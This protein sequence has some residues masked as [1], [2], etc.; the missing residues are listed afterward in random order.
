MI[1]YDRL[2]KGRNVALSTKKWNVGSAPCLPS[3]AGPSIQRTSRGV[4][5]LLVPCIVQRYTRPHLL[6]IDTVRK[7][8]PQ[9]NSAIHKFHLWHLDFSLNHPEMETPLSAGPKGDDS[10]AHSQSL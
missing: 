6:P 8:T 9:F 4:K 7:E 2:S 5:V 10:K 3:L 1:G